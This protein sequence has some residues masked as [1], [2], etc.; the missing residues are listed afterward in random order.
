MKGWKVL[1]DGTIK[2]FHLHNSKDVQEAGGRLITFLRQQEADIR[3]MG[4]VARYIVVSKG[5][6]ELM[7]L[8]LNG[9]VK[10]FEM[11]DVVVVPETIRP[12]VRMSA[13]DELL[14]RDVIDRNKR[15]SN[16]E[17][18]NNQSSSDKEV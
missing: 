11:L 5:D 4:L 3:K 7:A 1:L 17:R 2:E 14:Y 15:G 13:V 16:Y 18:K 8:F 6:Y 10:N 12:M 9:L